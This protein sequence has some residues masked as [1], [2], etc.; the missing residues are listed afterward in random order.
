M[1]RSAS[2]WWF[3]VIFL[4]CTTPAGQGSCPAPAGGP[5]EPRKQNCP[6]GYY[7]P[8]TEVCTRT[9]EQSM[10]CWVK[11]AAGCRSNAVPYMRLPDGGVFME[12]MDDGYC[13]ETKRLVCVGGY[14]QNDTC[15]FD[16]GGCDYDLYG[17]SPFKGNRSVG[18]AE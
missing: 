8:L 7:C 18:P 16:D 15:A 5:C 4:D 10:D 12:T 3:V 9:C 14:C 1:R 11:V 17:P 13:P 2:F 6:E